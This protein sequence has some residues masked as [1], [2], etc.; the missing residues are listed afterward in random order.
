MKKEPFTPEPAVE[1]KIFFRILGTVLTVSV[2][3]LPLKWGTLAAMT[4]AAGFFP[5]SVSAYLTITWPAH[6]F[7]I[8]SSFLLL[9]TLGVKKVPQ[10]RSG[11]GILA[12]LWSAGIILAS[13]PG[14]LNPGCDRTVAFAEI[15]NFSGI[16]AWALT[17]WIFLANF[18]EWGRRMAAA[19]LAGCAITA[20]NGFHQYL[21]GFDELREFINEQMA[22]GINVP[23][24]IQL[25]LEDTR[26]SSFLASSNALGGMLLLILPPSLFFAWKWGGAFTPVKWSRVLFLSVIA[27]IFGGALFLCRSR[28]ILLV[29]ILAGMLAAFSCPWFKL[30]YKLAAGVLALLLMIGAAWFARHYGRGFGSMTERADYLR[31]CAV[32]TL[33]NPVRGAGWGGFFYRHMLMKFSSTDEAARDPHNMVAAFAAQCGILS[34]VVVLAALLLPFVLL[35]KE[36][37]AGNWQCA[38]FWSGVFFTFH[39]LMDCDM[40]IPAIMAAMLMLWFSAVKTDMPHFEW[41]KTLIVLPVAAVIALFALWSNYDV[42]KGEYFLAEFTEFL[43]PSTPDAVRRYAGLPMEKFESQAAQARPHLAMIP[44]LAGDWYLYHGDVE[45]AEE[46]YAR[47]LLLNPRRPGIYRRLARLAAVKQDFPR[48]AEYLERAHRLFPGNPKY[49]PE[50]P[51]NQ[52]IFSKRVFDDAKS[53]E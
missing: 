2:F 34:A 28:S 12:A 35:W 9:L 38:V 3:L 4:E 6:S 50:H 24:A 20:V 22:N 42:L 13:L 44:E 31:T 19:L 30:R 43:N 32:L 25:K 18:P 26:I 15:A 41:R 23:K 21:F 5:D 7:G 14:V 8:W 53:A 47:A 29:L 10:L 36:R 16:A 51:E 27:V 52:H 1:N 33:E 40:H 37:F 45:R 48:A 49:L 39:I 11:S 17:M 46:R